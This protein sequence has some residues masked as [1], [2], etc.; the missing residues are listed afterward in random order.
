MG[1]RKTQIRILLLALTGLIFLSMLVILF[2]IAL[3]PYWISTE[4]FKAI[5]E[6]HASKLIDGQVRINHIAFK[7]EEG[8]E[9]IGLEIFT[10][11][12]FSPSPVAGIHSVKLRFDLIKTLRSRLIETSLEAEG[13]TLNWVRDKRGLTTLDYLSSYHNQSHQTRTSRKTDFSLPIPFPVKAAVQIRNLRAE[14]HDQMLGHHVQF[15]QGTVDAN[16]STSDKSVMV[17]LISDMILDDKILPR[18]SI[19]ISS[20]TLFGSRGEINLENALFNLDILATG[21]DASVTGDPNSKTLSGL[22]TI[23]LRLLLPIVSPLFN[24]PAQTEHASGI[25]RCRVH[26]YGNT[27]SRVGFDFQIDGQSIFLRK[28][29]LKPRVGPFDFATRT[30][31]YFDS[32]PGDIF[33]EKGEIRFFNVNRVIWNGNLMGM[34][35]PEPEITLKIGDLL[36]DGKGFP[37]QNKSI[38]LS[39]GMIRISENHGRFPQIATKTALFKGRLTSGMGEF[40]MEKTKITLPSVAFRLKESHEEA[41]IEN[42]DLSVLKMQIEF[43][44]FFPK[45]VEIDS[46]ATLNRVMIAGKNPGVVK[47][48]RIPDLHFSTGSIRMIETPHFGVKGPFSLKGSILFN[49]SSISSV[50]KTGPVFNRFDLTGSLE[51]G[52]LTDLKFNEYVM[53]L[54]RVK[55]LN[56]MTPIS[57]SKTYLH[58]TGDGIRLKSQD[59]PSLEMNRFNFNIDADEGAFILELNGSF[60]NSGKDK[61]LIQGK[62]DLDINKAISMGFLKEAAGS[63]VQGRISATWDVQGRIPDT[64]QQMLLKSGRL[65]PIKSFID[66]LDLSLAF[67]D[68]SEDLISKLG[69]RPYFS[70]ISTSKPITYRYDGKTDSGT[71]NCFL[72]AENIVIPTDSKEMKIFPVNAE[73]TISGEHNGFNSLNLTETLS[74]NTLGLNQTMEISLGGIDRILFTEDVTSFSHWL[75]VLKG[76]GKVTVRLSNIRP[77]SSFSSQI[78]L[79]GNLNLNGEIFIEPKSHIELKGRILSDGLDITVADFLK[80]DNLKSNFEFNKTYVTTPKSSTSLPAVPLSAQVMKEQRALQKENNIQQDIL[81]SLSGQ[82]QKRLNKNHSISFDSARIGSSSGI[83]EVR[84]TI[85]DLEVENGLP[86]LTHLESDLLGGTLLGSGLIVKKEKEMYLILNSLFSGLNPRNPVTKSRNEE[87]TLSGRFSAEFPITIHL[88]QVLQDLG[89]TLQFSHIGSEA[90]QGLLSI[91]DPYETNE[92]I[93]SIRRLLRNGKPKWIGMDVKNGIAALNGEINVKGVS[94]KLPGVERLNLSDLSGMKV[95]EKTLLSLEPLISF[96]RSASHPTL[97]PGQFR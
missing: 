59:S 63:D 2:A 3:F 74:S 86:K 68:I 62:G 57:L 19:R 58:F 26:A 34:K 91:L 67:K 24:L 43:D 9:I 28:T 15:H 21:I 5:L 12:I 11:E 52:S 76:K 92:T 54:L 84:K 6:K 64:G 47:N 1:N 61:V 49:E 25:L 85:I 96:L 73:V 10:R 33:I 71:I 27:S 56:K 16:F 89:F 17:T 42:I 30:I 14:I 77:F 20:Q 40:R 72:S 29:S 13:V 39:N 8:I 48:I 38:V 95:Y 93:V 36:L 78:D 46:S 44:K 18:I 53:T 80:I 69:I 66:H 32:I 75:D 79:K 51:T 22:I 60:S 94:V 4:Q 90:M 41:V 97:T 88:N 87:M 37:N 83:L 50:I 70:S 35:G 55:L 23:D 45:R 31:G 82:W 7:W 81:A 65:I